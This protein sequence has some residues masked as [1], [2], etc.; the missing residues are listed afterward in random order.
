MAAEIHWLPR[1][2]KNILSRYLPNLQQTMYLHRGIILFSKAPMEKKTRYYIMPTRRLRMVAVIKG[3]R[4]CKNFHGMQMA[5]PILDLPFLKNHCRFRQ[6]CIIDKLVLIIIPTALLL[7]SPVASHSCTFGNSIEHCRN[8]ILS[9]RLFLFVDPSCLGVTR[10]SF[11][12]P[13]LFKTTYIIV[14]LFFVMAR[15]EPSIYSLF[16]RR[17]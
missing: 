12:I 9:P 8:I 6:V 10:K 7:A 14:V 1:I 13:N 16:F 3:R 4:T 11:I 5:L 17:G 2:G 15:H